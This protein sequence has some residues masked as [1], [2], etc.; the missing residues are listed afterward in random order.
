MIVT[1]AEKDGQI[2]VAFPYSAYYVEQVK[3]VPGRR[4]VKETRSWVVPLEPAAYRGLQQ[5]FRDAPV[6][7]SDS[8]RAWA[9]AQGIHNEDDAKPELVDPGIDD[10]M[11]LEPPC[12][13]ECRGVPAGALCEHPCPQCG[14]SGVERPFLHQRVA[15]DLV[16]RAPHFALLMQM[17]VGKTRVIVD[18]LSYLIARREL[19]RVLVV[20]PMAVQRD[21]WEHNI[22]RY[23]PLAPLDKICYSLTGSSAAKRKTLLLASTAR[24]RWVTVNYEGLSGI[25]EDAYGWVRGAR[26]A[27]VLDESS[28]VKSPHAAQSKIC[29]HL[30]RMAARR[31]ILNG[32]PVT[33]SPLDTWSQFYF[34]DPNI[35]GHNSFSS[36]RAA[37]AVMGGPGGY[38]VVRYRAVDRI[39]DAIKPHSFRVLKKDCVDLPPKL[40]ETRLVDMEGAQALAY[41]QMRRDAVAELEGERV[42]AAHVLTRL[43]R[44]QQI[45]SGF[46]PVPGE[47]GEEPRVAELPS[48]KGRELASLMEELLA[49][50]LG[51]R[52]RKVIVW[53]RFRHDVARVVAD[54][55]AGTPGLAE[56][57]TGDTPPAARADMIRRF[58]DEALPRVFV[59]QVQAGGLGIT[60]TRADVEVYYSCTFSLADRLQSEDR[61]HRIGQRC[62]VTVIDLACRG[63]VDVAILRAHR[64]KKDLADFITGDPR[65]AFQRVAE[66][67]DE[68]V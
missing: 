8:L 13:G 65:E 33:Q 40:Y 57:F 63:T 53:C 16:R 58:Q 46:L 15:F 67:E 23:S 35:L 32:T 45:T 12:R 36:F 10:Y 14:G 9:A 34:L 24:V 30:G 18:A 2:E 39:R 59:G 55:C 62:S 3:A 11:F 51:D 4:Y 44:L 28:K 22:A 38:I 49:E 52:P 7:E 68:D 64:M 20:C 50:D 43:L 1:L 54:L 56:P 21:A 31:Y 19:D 48:A 27:V 61:A 17:G 42:T 29:H 25:Q 47:D 37:H 41:K 60:L 26:T 6:R 5:A 66:M